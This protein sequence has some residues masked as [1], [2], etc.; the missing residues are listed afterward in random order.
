MC[1][2]I[3]GSED[4]L[5]VQKFPYGVI[6]GPEVPIMGTSGPSITPHGNFWT[7]N[8]TTYE[9]LDPQLHHLRTSEP[10]ITPQRNFWTIEGPEVHA[11]CNC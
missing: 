4:H 3:Y 9:L 10:S 8:Y 11:W 2:V 7:I 6:E 5:M 1:G